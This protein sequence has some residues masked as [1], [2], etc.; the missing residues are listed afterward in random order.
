MRRKTELLCYFCIAFF[1]GVYFLL[2]SYKDTTSKDN[3]SIKK[4]SLNV[5]TVQTYD[6]S[7]K[8]VTMPFSKVPEKVIIN[9]INGAETLMALGVENRIIA[10]NMQNTDWG[11]PYD[12]R[13]IDKGKDL[14]KITYRDLTKE[15]AIL[16][17]PDC[18]IGWYSTFMDKR[19]GTT[20][21][22]NSRQVSTYIQ[23][24]S[25]M[26]KPQAGVRDECKFIED[27]GLIFHSEEKAKILI[28]AI[29]EKIRYIQEKTK[30]SYHPVVMVIEFSGNG[31]ITYGYEWLVGDMIRQLGGSIPCKS[32]QISYEELIEINPDVI[33][34]VYFNS[35]LESV[36]S[37]YFSNPAFAS[38]RATQNLRVVPLRLD[39]MYTTGVR[40]IN[41][42]KMLA[43]GMYPGSQGLDDEI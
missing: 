41:G 25:N 3:I 37:Q 20:G 5:A 34:V 13:Y 33:F 6:S 18:I 23:S 12:D 32:G 39:Y 8:L 1:L 42:L 14:E 7:K 40:T 10:I 38:L 2:I 9:R 31:L 4:N 15:E 36:M 35:D 16:L 28:D 17:N 26:V 11:K 22:W 27:M 24:T 43:K 21:F 30:E 29:W 19:L